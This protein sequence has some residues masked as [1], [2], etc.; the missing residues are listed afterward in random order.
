MKSIIS[1]SDA[2]PLQISLE[3]KLALKT[4]S[5]GSSPPTISAVAHSSR[6]DI[7]TDDESMPNAVDLNAAERQNK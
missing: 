5:I 6:K 1:S 7:G 3:L 4:Q 2:S